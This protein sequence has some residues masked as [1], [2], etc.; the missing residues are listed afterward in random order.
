MKSIRNA[1]AAVFYVENS[2]PQE[3][4]FSIDELF[5]IIADEN[6][7]VVNE[8]CNWFYN[9]F[10]GIDEIAVNTGLSNKFQNILE[11][12]AMFATKLEAY[13]KEL[14]AEVREEGV[15]ETIKK[16]K[17]NGYSVEKIASM[18]NMSKDDVLSFL[19]K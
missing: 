19:N 3:L 10:D 16:L 15:A 17:S 1:V 5:R 12:K 13:K 11:E 14:L 9:Y 2:S 8:F 6:L 7:E 4:L 18:L